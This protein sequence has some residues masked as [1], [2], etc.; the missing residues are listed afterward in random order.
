M[1]LTQDFS[2]TTLLMFWCQII[3]SSGRFPMH[4]K[5]YIST[6]G[7][8]PPKP[9]VPP[10]PHRDNRRC[11]QTA[12]SWEGKM[13][14]GSDTAPSQVPAVQSSHPGRVDTSRLAPMAR[15]GAPGWSQET[16]PHTQHLR[17]SWG[18][19]DVNFSGTFFETCIPLHCSVFV[20]DLYNFAISTASPALS[21]A[22]AC[23][24]CPGSVHF[25]GDREQLEVS[26]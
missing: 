1:P 9:V 10:P 7:P 15:D 8:C 4:C 11:L 24:T 26:A 5:M 20:P 23:P 3:L 2:I 22:L 17:R 21:L 19:V 12:A 6:P 18:S 13:D 25:G 14:P 16:G